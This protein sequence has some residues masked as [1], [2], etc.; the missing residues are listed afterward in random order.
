MTRY[1]LTTPT[2]PAVT[3]ATHDGPDPDP[4]GALPIAVALTLAARWRPARVHVEPAWLGWVVVADGA[5]V[6]AIDYGPVPEPEDPRQ[7]GMFGGGS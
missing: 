7:V 4:D 1:T 6:A 5:T 2:G 3:L